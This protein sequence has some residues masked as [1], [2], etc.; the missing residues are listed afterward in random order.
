MGKEI[1]EERESKR[2]ERAWKMNCNAVEK[3]DGKIKAREQQWIE[4][5]NGARGKFKKL[6]VLRKKMQ[7]KKRKKDLIKKK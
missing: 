3:A 5:K 7:I 6:D 4:K 2:Y 1:G